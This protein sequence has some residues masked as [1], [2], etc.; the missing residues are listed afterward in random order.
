MTLIAQFAV[1]ILLIVFS[2]ICSGLNIS[3]MSLGVADLKRQ[4]KLGNIAAMRVLPLRINSNLSLASIILSNVA[5]ISAISLV[6]DHFISGQSQIWSGVIA[7]SLSTILIVL[8]GEIF[9]QALFSRN[10][11]KFTSAFSDLLRIMIIATYPV[12]K[13]LQLLLDRLFGDEATRLHSRREL[14]ILIGEHFD[15]NQS[16]LDEDEVEIMQGALALSEKT[17]RE[18]TTKISQVYWIKPDTLIDDKKIDEIKQVGRSRIPVFNQNLTRCYGVLL[19][20]DLV[21]LDF[22]KNPQ[23]VSQLSLHPTKVIGSKTALDTLFRKFILSGTH[24]LPVER[25]G[26][27]IGIVTIEDLLEEIVGHEIVDETDHRTKRQ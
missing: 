24:L 2:A 15:N 26:R 11:L 6:I 9:P 22:D 3:L 8:F 14:G 17:V 25:D 23:S 5:V 20:K 16:E 10:A 4:A 13:P 1:V 21:D 7:G 12:S 27:I 19:M 18:I